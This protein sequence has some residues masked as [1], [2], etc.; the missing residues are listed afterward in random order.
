MKN[1]ILLF[2]AAAFLSCQGPSTE[3][4]SKPDSSKLTRIGGE[5]DENGC[6][7]AAGYTWS[8][9]KKDCIRPWEGTITMNVT[10]TSSN[11]VTAAFVFIDSVKQQAEVFLKEEK[12][13]VVLDRVSPHLFANETYKL[14]QEAHCWSLVHNNKTVYQ[15]KK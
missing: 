4:K 8:K 14:T 1:F 2:T 10:D 7:T 15:E 6:L 3:N 13:G 11:F 9:V 5:K 12:E